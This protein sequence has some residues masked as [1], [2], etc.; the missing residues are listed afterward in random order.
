MDGIKRTIDAMA[1]TKL[2]TFHWHITDSQSFPI[3][4]PSR[5]EFSKLGAFNNRKVYT[6]DDVKDV[7]QFF[8]K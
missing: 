1:M 6:V 4:L 8:L 2:N 7:S 3:K 5:P